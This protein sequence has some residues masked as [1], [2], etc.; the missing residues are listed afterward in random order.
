MD[1]SAIENS[2]SVENLTDN[3]A[4]HENLHIEQ[5]LN[6]AAG[7]TDEALHTAAELVRKLRLEDEE[8]S[9]EVVS[10]TEMLLYNHLIDCNIG[11]ALNSGKLYQSHVNVENFD[12]SNR[13]ISNSCVGF[14]MS[15]LADLPMK[16][17]AEGRNQDRY[18]SDYSWSGKDG[19]TNYLPDI[20]G[21]EVDR[22][23]FVDELDPD[24]I[25][26]QVGQH[27]QI[28]E[29]ALAA[30][31]NHVFLIRKNPDG[32]V[33]M[34]HSGANV[35]ENGRRRGGPS[36]VNETTLAGYAKYHQRTYG[37][38]K[39]AFLTIRDIVEI[40]KNNHD[41]ETQ[42]YPDHILSRDIESYAIST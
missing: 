31:G 34:V 23:N 11:E 39:F 24:N 41:L 12:G 20:C 18:L 7:L 6:A 10:E 38:M 29:Y 28:N 35:D 8:S 32:V 1:F 15:A 42:L 26:E 25:D 40:S 36:R 4:E 3:A 9:S 33:K 17:P 2:G 37:D 22:C 30:F 16:I 5:P 13:V 19:L 21:D 14:L 27:L